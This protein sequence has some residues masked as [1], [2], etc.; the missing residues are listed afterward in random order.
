MGGLALTLIAAA[1]GIV[2]L[3]P[4]L[5]SAV[6][7]TLVLG[8]AGDAKMWEMWEMQEMD[9]SH[10]KALKAELESWFCPLPA[11]VLG[12]LAKAVLEIL[13]GGIGIGERPR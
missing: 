10:P 11:A 1:L 13:P 12:E 4:F 5:E 7:L 2:G 9:V 6:E 3:A 8:D